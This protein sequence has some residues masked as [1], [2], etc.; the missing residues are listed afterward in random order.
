MGEEEK[1]GKPEAEGNPEILGETL[2]EPLGGVD[3]E[4]EGD[5]VPS[6]PPPPPSPPELV[7]AMEVER[8]ERK[9]GEARSLPLGKRLPV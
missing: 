2:E 1:E 5:R 9:E 3:R 7:G 6:L 4:E 8:E